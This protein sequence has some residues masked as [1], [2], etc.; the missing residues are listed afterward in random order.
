MVGG[1]WRKRGGEE[2]AEIPPSDDYTSWRLTA[3]ILAVGYGGG[4]DPPYTVPDEWRRSRLLEDPIAE[5]GLWLFGGDRDN[6]YCDI[7]A[8]KGEGTA[9]GENDERDIGRESL[10]NDS[11]LIV[12]VADSRVHWLQPCDLNDGDCE[13]ELE[14][15]GRDPDGFFV[16][17]A[18]WQ[19]WLLSNDTPRALVYKFC[20]LEGAA[21][22]DRD[23]L[24]GQYRIE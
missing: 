10:S 24:L 1:I 12:E 8:V 22:N 2:S 19:V 7:F 16:G 17:F 3:F 11:I 4:A 14:I 18:D 5:H 13:E 21:E 9:F 6:P 20:T 23:E 15:S